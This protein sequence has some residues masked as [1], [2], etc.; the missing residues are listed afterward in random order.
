VGSKRCGREAGGRAG[1]AAACQ[2]AW[3]RDH[4]LDAEPWLRERVAELEADNEV[5][6]AQLA[7]RDAQLEAA[8]ARLA[9]LAGQ[10]EEFRC[11][12]GKDSATSSK[13]PSSDSP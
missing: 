3:R 6:A 13:P 4:G 1:T 9:V 7:A 2:P 8:L 5:L 10:V 11:R 12:L